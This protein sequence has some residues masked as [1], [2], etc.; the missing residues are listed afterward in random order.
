V[1]LGSADPQSLLFVHFPPI[2]WLAELSPRAA[3]SLAD[4]KSKAIHFSPLGAAQD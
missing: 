2:A 3:N 1:G 4:V